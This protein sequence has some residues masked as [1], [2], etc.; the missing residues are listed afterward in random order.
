MEFG[1]AADVLR[2]PLHPY[3]QLLLASVAHVG[4]KWEKLEKMSDLETKEYRLVGCRFADRCPNVMPKCRTERPGA[5]RS[6]DGR[7]V[8]CFLYE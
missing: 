2:K 6:E 8:Y 5:T 1:R 4:I 3:T 7:D